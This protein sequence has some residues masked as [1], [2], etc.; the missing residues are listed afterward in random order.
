MRN[1]RIEFPSRV[2]P[3][4][5]EE[6][7][8]TALRYP[9]DIGP[10]AMVIDFQ[11]Y[12]FSQTFGISSGFPKTSTSIV[13]PLP[14]Q[15]QDAYSIIINQ[16]DMGFGGSFVAENMSNGAS[17]TDVRAMAEATL[18]KAETM[19]GDLAEGGVLGALGS[20]GSYAKFIS[21]GMLDGLPVDGLSLAVDVVNE[22]AI[23]PHTTL[24]FDGVN[25]KKFNFTWKLSPRSEEE[26]EAIKNII[27]KI[28][29]HILPKYS[30]LPGI[31]GSTGT[32]S[33]ALLKYPDLANIRFNGLAEDHYFKFK[34]GMISDFSVDYSPD[35][36]VVFAGGK[37]GVITISC[38]FSEAQIHTSGYSDEGGV[39]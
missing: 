1:R 7:T 17:L 15:I 32:V 10:N 18:S 6:N 24:N 36:N 25:L 22:S 26:S 23:N 16:G 21:R 3:S 2:I 14:Q 9:L 4:A 31:G 19:G 33:R 34:P 35:G 29:S 11:K 27:S 12:N 13:L 37:P 38:S 28:K 20:A 8:F 5:R 30:S 39:E